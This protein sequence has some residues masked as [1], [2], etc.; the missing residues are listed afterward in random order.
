MKNEIITKDNYKEPE[1]FGE[2]VNNDIFIDNSYRDLAIQNIKDNPI[3]YI[4]FYFKKLF[5]FVTYDLN[6]TYPN[7]FNLLHII[8]KIL[9][10]FSTI[11]SIIILYKQKNYFNFVSL[12]YIVNILVI[13]AFFIL[14][15]YSISLLP[16]QIIISAILI[17]KLKPN[18]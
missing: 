6:S 2:Y 8:P 14:P 13:S 5:S 9:F 16:F 1:T 7:Y 11:I 10:S 3:K 15:R 18:I 4:S 12:L 17:K